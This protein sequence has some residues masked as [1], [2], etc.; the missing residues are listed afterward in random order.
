MRYN[1]NTTGHTKTIT[2]I[3]E[4]YVGRENVKV[5]TGILTWAALMKNFWPRIL[6]SKRSSLQQY[7]PGS[8]QQH[9]HQE[10]QKSIDNHPRPL[11]RRQQGRKQQQQQPETTTLCYVKAMSDMG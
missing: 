2:M 10:Q 11:R 1:H 3:R 7:D 4:S 8:K 5:R 9:R 6:S